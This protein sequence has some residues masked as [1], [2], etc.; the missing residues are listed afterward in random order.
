VIP[1]RDH[2]VPSRRTPPLILAIAVLTALTVAFVAGCDSGG[3]PSSSSGPSGSASSRGPSPTRWPTP[4]LTA[5]VALGAA[6]NDMKAFIAAFNDAINKSDMQALWGA[7]DGIVKTL[8]SLN[9]NVD[10]IAEYDSTAGLAAKYRAVLPPLTD[11]AT[12]LRDAIT[13]GDAKTVQSASLRVINGL[14]GYFGLREELAKWVTESV[15]QQKT[16]FQ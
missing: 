7:A 3:Q 4:V 6:D 2:G 16:L 5:V 8:D 9:A 10:R 11:A 14:E 15:F 1:A 12:D 13:K